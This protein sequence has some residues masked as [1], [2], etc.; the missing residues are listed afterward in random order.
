MMKP[1][2][3]RSSGPER[4][5]ALQTRSPGSR[6]NQMAEGTH[7][8]W[9]EALGCW[10]GGSDQPRPGS[11]DVRQP[12]AK[13]IAEPTNCHRCS[14]LPVNHDRPRAAMLYR[15]AHIHQ[16][17]ARFGEIVM[18]ESASLRSRSHIEV[19]N[20]DQL[21]SWE[22]AMMRAETSTSSLSFRSSELSQSI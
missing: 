19:S 22:V 4:L 16:N 20:S 2:L 6:G 21:S 15:I 1:R 17:F 14:F 13:T 8:L 18:A 5:S 11:G 9:S 7:P 3:F 10:P 12:F